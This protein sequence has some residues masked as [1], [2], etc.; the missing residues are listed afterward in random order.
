M[1]LQ[2]NQKQVFLIP[3]CKSYAN[4]LMGRYDIS[5]ELLEKILEK[6]PHDHESL[7]RKG[8]VLYKIQRY[9]EALICLETAL[10]K[11][12]FP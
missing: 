4:Y 12:R 8:F 3:Y 6:V 2:S 7:L 10:L 5:L 1:K 11:S 9:D